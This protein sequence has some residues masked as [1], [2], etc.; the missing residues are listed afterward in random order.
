MTAE[1]LTGALK[2]VPFLR[3]MLLIMD[4]KY[5]SDHYAIVRLVDLSPDRTDGHDISDWLA[6][7][8]TGFDRLSMTQIE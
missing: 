7:G 4:S 3:C 6:D 1:W 2:P 8:H 5:V